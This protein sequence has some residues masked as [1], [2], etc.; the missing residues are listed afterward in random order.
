MNRLASV[1][2]APAIISALAVLPFVF[3]ELSNRRTYHEG[4]PALLFGLLWLLALVFVLI[5]RSLRRSV[6]PG[7]RAI[8]H[9]I[10]LSLGLMLLALIA[11]LWIEVILD[12]MP[13]FLGV[14]SCD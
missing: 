8:A 11:G 14:P 10:V 1:L 7:L 2:K 13:C 3:L 12:Q 5:L 9:P 4:F 6:R